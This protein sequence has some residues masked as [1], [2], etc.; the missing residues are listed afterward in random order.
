V[1][2]ENLIGSDEVTKSR[3]APWMLGLLVIGQVSLGVDLAGL[4]RFCPVLV[5]SLHQP[6]APLTR[7]IGCYR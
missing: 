2:A 7:L 3:R 6:E 1:C 4:R 5:P